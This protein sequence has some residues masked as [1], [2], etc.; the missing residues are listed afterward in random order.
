[1]RRNADVLCSMCRSPQRRRPCSGLLEVS[2]CTPWSKKGADKTSRRGGE[3]AKMLDV[4][5]GL[6]IRFGLNWNYPGE[7][8]ASSV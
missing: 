2:P 5:D 6:G 4:V 8:G 7:G 3:E 1:M